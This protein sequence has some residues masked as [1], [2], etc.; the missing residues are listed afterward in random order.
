METWN[1]WLLTH[2]CFC[3]LQRSCWYWL[4]APA[5]FLAA[6]HLSP[7]VNCHNSCMTHLTNGL[8]C[9]RHHRG[10][11]VEL[12]YNPC[13]HQV[14]ICSIFW[15]SWPPSQSVAHVFLCC[16]YTPTEEKKPGCWDT[17]LIIE[18]HNVVVVLQWSVMMFLNHVWRRESSEKPCRRHRSTAD[19]Q[20]WMWYLQYEERGRLFKKPKLFMM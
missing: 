3:W 13:S 17:T 14:Y 7:S 15:G 1:H 8:S 12:Q 5:Q 18:H 19:V 6:E 9:T 20:Y 11:L 4:N 10:N 16:I 2:L